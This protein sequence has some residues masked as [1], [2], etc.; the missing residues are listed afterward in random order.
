MPRLRKE[1]REHAVRMLMNRTSQHQVAGQL[2][3][4]KSTISRMVKRLRET[5][6][7]DDGQR[8]GRPRATTRQEDAYIHWTHLRQQF[9]T[10][11]ETAAHIRGLH[12]SARTIRNR[13]REFGLNARRPYVGL[14]LTPDR[15]RRR[16]EW[17]TAH[18]PGVFS[19]WQWR[20]VLFSDESRFLPYRSDRRTRVY[21]RRSERFS[22][23]CVVERDRF[24]DDGLMVWAGISHRQ[25][26]PLIFNEGPF[27]AVC[28]RD[29]VLQPVVVPFVQH[30]NVT[31]Q[32]DNARPHVSRICQAYLADNN[33]NV[34]PWPAFN[35]DLSPIEHLWD[36]LDR[37]VRKRNP[38]PTS[39]DELRQA[40]TEEWENITIRQVNG[41]I[42]SMHRRVRAAMAANRGHTR[43]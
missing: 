12:V 28:Y 7:T 38:P 9:R 3:V 26:T 6:T 29:T 22:D 13:L 21:R 33:V 1:Q 40:L 19:L 11:T 32:H 39:H 30:H 41:L 36:I 18:R 43:Y 42:N 2:G 14:P 31:F 20:E 4:H 15:R 35:P 17:L 24:G 5:G 16:M 27:T 25:K 23:A 37:R 8:S 34:M 10:A